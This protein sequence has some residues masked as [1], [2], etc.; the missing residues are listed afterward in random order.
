MLLPLPEARLLRLDLLREPLPER[1]LLLLELGVVELLDLGLAKLASLH[2]LLPI[3]LIVSILGRSDEIEHVGSNEQ[4]TELA[5]VGMLLI[6]D[7]GHA[8]EVLTTLDGPA[9]GRD[10]VGRAADDRERHG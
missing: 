4:R 1:L 8:P 7:F 9:V 3:E 6:L 2:L 10:D 5:E